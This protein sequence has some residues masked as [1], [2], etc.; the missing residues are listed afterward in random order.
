MAWARFD[1][2]HPLNIKVR[3]LSDAAFRL[4]VSAICFTAAHGQDGWI[5]PDDLP[6][7]SDVKQ[8][9]KAATELVERGRWHVPGHDCESK[10]CRPIKEGWLIHDYLAYNPPAAAVEK[11]RTARAEAGRAGG[12]A[13]SKSRAT[14]RAVGEANA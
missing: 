4:D 6:L 13:S 1:D 9:A 12:K 5:G 10:W 14:L 7:C 3:K 2:K 11:K 8:P